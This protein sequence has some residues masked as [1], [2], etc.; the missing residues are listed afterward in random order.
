ML[1][2]ID[3]ARRRPIAIMRGA[4]RACSTAG[5]V[6]TRDLGGTASHD[7]SSR[8]PICR[9]ESLDELETARGL[10]ELCRPDLML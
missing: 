3:E 8:T 4:R 10:P 1:R 2:H 5:T 9:D 6:R 7:R